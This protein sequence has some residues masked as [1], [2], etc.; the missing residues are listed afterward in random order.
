MRTFSDTPKTFTFHYTFKDFDTAQV[1]C[2]AILGY[3]TGTYKQPVI[4]ATYHNDNQGGHANQLVL[5][6]AEDRK[7]NKVFKRICDSFKDYYNQPEDMTDE[8]LDAM[9]QENEVE[10]LEHQRVVPLSEITQEE[11]NEQHTLMAF[12]SYHDQL[13]EHLSMNYQ[14][15]SQDD[16]GAILETISQAF[17]HLYDMVVEGQLLVK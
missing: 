1:A 4:D 6:Y 16:L 14:E 12:I 15:M 8:E 5:E 17:N 10:E 3:M 9:V 2:H 13:A 11:A 7:L